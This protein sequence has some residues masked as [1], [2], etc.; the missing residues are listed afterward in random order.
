[1]GLPTAQQTSQVVGTD[2]H[3]VLVPTP[4]GPVPVPLPH[5]FAGAVQGATV[6]TVLVAGQPAATQDSV[7]VNNPPHLPTPPGVSFQVP[8][9]NQGT[10]LMGSV[11]VL[12][13]GKAL[14]RQ[15]DPVKTCNFPAPM[16]VGT[17][18]TGAPTV[19]TG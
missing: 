14:A 15:G 19:L 11:T 6:P 18:V 17:L 16:P 12:A 7:A 13:G 5:P 2:T 8:P 4:G 10:V 1:M 3:M 9:D